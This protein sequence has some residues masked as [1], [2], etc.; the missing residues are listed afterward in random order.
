MNKK[1]ITLVIALAAMTAWAQ[2]KQS[3]IGYVA[4]SNID[5]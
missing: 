2:E 4:M 3:K 1:L 5:N